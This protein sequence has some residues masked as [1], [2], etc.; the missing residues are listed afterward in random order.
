M[1]VL[2][3]SRQ[4]YRRPPIARATNPQRMNWLWRLIC[5]AAELRP[6]DV[7]EALHASQIPV[8]Q[9]RA[10]SWLASDLDDSFFPISI[11]EVERNLRAL[12]LLREA[13]GGNDELLAAG[14]GDMVPEWAMLGADTDVAGDAMEAW[15]GGVDGA[16]E[17]VAGG[18]A[19]AD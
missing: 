5:E 13:V 4:P 17:R 2:D 3:L 9:A 1:P 10:R 14:E 7:V 16:D 18:A 19:D 8:D 12:L 11:A 15:D 6:A